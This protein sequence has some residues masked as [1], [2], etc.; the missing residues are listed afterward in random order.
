MGGWW[1]LLPAAKWLLECWLERRE[2]EGGEKGAGRMEDGGEERDGGRLGKGLVGDWCMV[3]GARGR[4]GTCAGRA[5][6]D[7]EQGGGMSCD[8]SGGAAAAAAAAA[9]ASASSRLRWA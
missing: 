5:G 4:M 9:A 3:L 1:V 8:G 6:M 2:A 7:M